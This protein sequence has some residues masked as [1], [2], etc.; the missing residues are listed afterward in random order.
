VSPPLPCDKLCCLVEAAKAIPRLYASE[1]PEVDQ[2]LGADEFLP[3]FIYVVSQS[4]IEDLY[5]LKHVLCMLVDPS[6]RLSEA[7]YY[8][9]SFEAAVEH[10]RHLPAH[11]EAD[12]AES[13][14]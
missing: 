14:T 10:L 7:G 4:A 1:H 2:P 12:K 9:A 8:L 6:K 13:S 3:I 5:L 11:G